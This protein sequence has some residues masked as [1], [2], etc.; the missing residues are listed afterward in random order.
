MDKTIKK[1]IWGF[2]AAVVTVLA[3]VILVYLGLAFY[4]RDRFALNTW[5]NGVYCTGS[6]VQEVSARLLEQT[7]TPAEMIVIGYDGTGSNCGEAKYTISLGEISYAL[8]YETALNSFLADQNSWLWIANITHN[9]EYT[10]QPEISFDEETL[11]SQWEKIAADIHTE[12]DYR[13][14]YNVDDGYTLYDGLH[15]R[16]DEEKSYEIIKN[17]IYAS[18]DS[19]NLNVNLIEEESYYDVSMSAE[20]Q[21]LEKLWNRIEL[22]QDNGPVYD[23]GEGEE[24]IEPG[25]MAA[26][27][28]KDVAED[29]P[30]GET[31]SGLPVEGEEGY[32]LLDEAA[33][34]E[35]IGSM[36]EIHDTY[37]KDWEFQSTRGDIVSI[38]GATYGTT[39]DQKR[40]VQWLT[41]YLE[42]L[43]QK[44]VNAAGFD[45]DA[46]GEVR[47]PAYTRE[48]YNRS[49]AGV[50]DTYIEV[51]MGIQKLYYYEAGELKLETD[52]VTGNVRK[53]MNTP[54]GV[55]YV[56]SKQK[57]R[58][59][60]GEG[61]TS[62][63]SFWM[64]VKG[65]VGIHDAS[66]RDEF[67]GD[68]YKSNG[69]HGCINLP[70]DVMA[71]LY[72]MVEVGT[73]VVMFYGE[74]PENTA[75]TTQT[76]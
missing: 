53:K 23:F 67:G 6:T 5:I 3:L 7:E 64:P 35:W 33:V 12:A 58:I 31:A 9:R 27:L 13:I 39:M 62:P 75:N 10:L 46:S 56:Y 76:K 45:V 34:S 29:Q 21:E 26:F 44:T 74:E 54:E 30:E 63:V 25:Q 47:I 52:I 59:L 65:A 17:A 24:Q 71:E 32:F 69:S 22:F 55:N 72:D 37:G 66:W 68:I 70:S 57:N 61:Y 15:N 48:A 43:L 49:C 36:A 28:K 42:Q 1:Q 18:A 51:D 19:A 20:Q 14:D 60:R 38:K 73:P 41:D 40:E 11:K 50:G 16:L 4:Y 8:D 2:V